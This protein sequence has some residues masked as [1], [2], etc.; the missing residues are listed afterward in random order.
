MAARGVHFAL[1]E[2][3]VA[4]LRAVGDEARL[5]HVSEKIEEPLFTSAK[6][7]VSESDKAWDAMHRAL[8]DGELT[9]DGG[10]YPLNH[11]VLAGEM[12][13][14]ND[15]Y[16]LSLKTPGQVRDIAAA[17]EKLTREDFRRRYD[18]INPLSYDGEL[19]DE[20]FDYTWAWFTNVRDLYRRAAQDG[21]YVLFSVDL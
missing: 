10:T 3:E 1:S 21:R 15:D 17:L 8:T 20:D 16:I 2:T 19:D 14:A 18:A 12:L 13:Y 11:T 7:Y 4:A 9:W 5:A 6:H